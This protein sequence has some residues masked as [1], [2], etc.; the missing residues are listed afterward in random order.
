[1]R[2][3][4][5]PRSA[6]VF[7]GQPTVLTVR[8]V[9]TAT[10]ISGQRIRVLGV[11][12]RWVRLDQEQLSLFPDAAGVALLTVTLP[13]G[14]PA[15]VRRLG[16]EVQ[17]LTAPGER[18]VVEAE[19]TVPAQ[20]GLKVVLDPVSAAGGRST[21]V[22]V[23]IDNVGN[24]PV[25]VDLDGTDE[26]AQIAFAFKPAGANLAPG[27]RNLAT[28]LLRAKR[29]LFGSP[30]IRSFK[31]DV[32]PAQ[33]PV[34]AFGTWVQKPL[35]SRGAIALIGL[36]LAVTVFA[37]ILT[38]S[39][40]RVVGQ[41]DADRNLALQVAQAGQ[42]GAGSGG[43]SS[44]AGTVSL[45]TSGAGVPGVTVQIY[46]SGNTA[47]PLSSAATSASGGYKFQGLGAGT[48]KIS[49]S[50]A[51]FTEL[52]YP[53]SLTADNASPVTLNSGQ[54]LTGIN[55]LLGGVP[56]SVAGTVEGAD[57]TG[58]TVSLEAV[59]QAATA[60]SGAT[61]STEATTTTA[62]T[63]TATAPATAS[64]TPS[65]VT[66]Q[67]VAAN[68]AF[69]LTQIPSPNTYQ[70]VVAKQGFA[71]VT[72]TVD[73]GSGE[74]RNG[75]VITLVQGN[76]SITGQVNGPSG[77]LGGATISAS[78]GHN[79]V[80]TVSLTV[81]PI[82]SF[83]LNNL[84]TPDTLTLTVS[85]TGFATQTLTVSLSADQHLSGVSVTLVS[86]S[87]SISGQVNLATGGPATGVTVTVTNGQV[88]LQTVTLSA[89][90]PGSYAMAG[91][92]V[93]NTYT[94]TFSRPDLVS[95]T[96]DVTLNA[97]N[98]ST[99]S[100]VNATMVAA[101]ATLSGVVTADTTSS[102]RASAGDTTS[103]TTG[104]GVVPITV[105]LTSSSATYQVVT[106]TSGT[107]GAY[108]LDGVTPGTYSVSFSR[109][110]GQP[111]TFIKT[112][113]AG[114]A[115]TLSPALPAAASICGFVYQ[116]AAGQS[117]GTTSTAPSTS[118]A[119]QVEVQLFQANQYPSGQSQVVLTGTDG[120]FEFDNVAGPQLYIIQF[121]F[122]QGA[123][124]QFTIETST[125]LGKPDVV[126]HASKGEVANPP[127][128]VVN[129]GGA[130]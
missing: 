130:A 3:D 97:L 45:L 20:L 109:T 1:M 84:P 68:G 9:N 44:I 28:A 127:Y 76:G 52:W 4:V 99:Q 71:T 128:C 79:T 17:E 33:P 5:E 13:P 124:G 122:P 90:T 88:K 21:T 123:A 93:P 6:T 53:T 31:V 95:Q 129:T 55:A 63:G 83:T 125:A 26:E 35:L 8:V 98:N 120:Y 62:A 40:S 12:P 41:S 43:S 16:I 24:S 51:G 107:I 64:S 108:E 81:N 113:A 69:D 116:T 11:D 105:T 54:N 7:P 15:G 86:G 114:S 42:N 85:A 103:P 60:T 29:P 27:E 25:D 65:V 96:K 56:A 73:L 82:G 70:L 89:G 14:I 50:G 101:T 32:G 36:V 118:V 94:V 10:V 80:S 78:D 34:S 126:C 2:V 48:Y 75:I 23:I 37:I 115:T 22:G 59:T 74:Q 67:T 49:F 30:K 38:V 58:A 112:L 57:P 39:L 111:Y 92:A 110:G 18:Q 47:S 66:T 117:P 121:S 104:G 106:A 72:Q 19:L 91:L 61:S 77:P 46:N 119:Q 100:G 87:G 102:C